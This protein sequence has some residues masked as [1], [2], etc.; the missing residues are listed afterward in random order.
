MHALC[1]QSASSLCSMQI[2]RN[3]VRVSSGV[4]TTVTK[5]QQLPATPCVIMTRWSRWSSLEQWAI[6]LCT[7]AQCTILLYWVSFCSE[8]RC[9][10]RGGNNVSDCMLPLLT[11]VHQDAVSTQWELPSTLHGRLQKQGLKALPQ[12]QEQ[13]VPWCLQPS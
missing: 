9:V 5:S 11:C 2:I 4:I 12:Q 10:Y 8:G 7:A 6:I 1:L 13:N 3:E